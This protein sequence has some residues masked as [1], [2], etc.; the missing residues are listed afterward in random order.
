MKYTFEPYK[1]DG[2]PRKWV[3][4]F[5]PPHDEIYEEIK[6]SG[7][8]YRYVVGYEIIIPYMSGNFDKSLY[9]LE[10]D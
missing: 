1:E 6:K 3:G 2:S 10:D 9:E 4:T 8:L 5:R 7:Q